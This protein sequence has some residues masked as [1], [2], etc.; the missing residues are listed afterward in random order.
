MSIHNK[1]EYSKEN[2]IRKKKNKFIIRYLTL[3]DLE[4]FNNLLRYAF[5]VSNNELITLGY[6]IDEIKQAKSAVLSKA[7]VLGWF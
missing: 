4:M 5:Q 7:K 1:K 3:E 2:I 6:E